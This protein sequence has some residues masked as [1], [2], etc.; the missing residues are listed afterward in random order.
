MRAKLTDEER[1]ERR[2]EKNRRWYAAHRKKSAEEVSA[3]R[4]ALGKKGMA[5]RWGGTGEKTVSRRV[6]ESDAALLEQMAPR[7]ADAVRS[8]LG[9]AA[10]QPPGPTGTV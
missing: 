3:A 10:R 8:L 7:T 2:R 5:S 9:G 1:A 4:R 6:Y